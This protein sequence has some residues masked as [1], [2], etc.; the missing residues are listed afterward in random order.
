M[1]LPYDHNHNGPYF[2]LQKYQT[3]RSNVMK[4]YHKFNT[5]QYLITCFQL[6]MYFCFV[7]MYQYLC[8]WL[9]CKYA[10]NYWHLFSINAVNISSTPKTATH[11]CLSLHNKLELPWLWQNI[12]AISA[13][14]GSLFPPVA[15]YHWYILCDKVSKSL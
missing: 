11:L 9:T 7:S 14:A 15:R 4:I 6:Y 3:I 10:V 12:F 13:T 1:Q 8:L 5:Y 2:W